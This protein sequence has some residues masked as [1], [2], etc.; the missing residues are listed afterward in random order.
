[1]WSGLSSVATATVTAA[2]SA[3]GGGG[4][5]EHDQQEQRSAATAGA[6]GGKRRT[7]PRLQHVH[8]SNRSSPEPSPERNRLKPFTTAHSNSST[9][10]QRSPIPSSSASK[11]SNTP[12]ALQQ[13]QQ[14][15]YNYETPGT[16]RG[17]YFGSNESERDASNND[18]YGDASSSEDS[19]TELLDAVRGLESSPGQADDSTASALNANGSTGLVGNGGIRRELLVQRRVQEPSQ[20]FGRTAWD[21]WEQALMKPRRS[22]GPR[23]SEGGTTANNSNTSSRRP[24]SLTPNV[25]GTSL[26]SRRRASPSKGSLAQDIAAI[27][28][29]TNRCSSPS[30]PASP[31][32]SAVK[33]SR[34][35]F[36]MDLLLEV[37]I[38]TGAL[39]L[40]AYR[41]ARL[42]TPLNADLEP[43]TPIPLSPFVMLIVAIPC[44][45]LFRRR[46]WQSNYM[47]PFTDER[48]YRT[49]ATVDDGFAAGA[50]VPVL[51]AAGFLWDAVSRGEEGTAYFGSVRPLMDVWTAAGK[52]PPSTASV[53]DFGAVYRTVVVSRISL[54]LSTSINS[55]VLILNIVLSRTFLSVEKVPKDNTKRLLGSLIVSG[56]ISLFLW[57]LLA[58]NDAFA[59]GESDPCDQSVN[60]AD[61]TACTASPY[62]SPAEAAISSFIYQMSLYTISRLVRR[63][64]T[65][66]ELSLATGSGISL[67]LEF[68][69]LTLTRVSLLHAT[70]YGNTL[71]KETTAHIRQT[72]RH[73]TYLPLTDSTRPVSTRYDSRCLHHRFLALTSSCTLSSIRANALTSST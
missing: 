69:R 36:R 66:G 33:Q 16:E 61:D 17:A 68:W 37:I 20:H 47:F 30:A 46:N 6:G 34:V 23:V 62:I 49:P 43:L 67:A 11:S 25:T 9:A 22:P 54:L 57:T 40:T 63:G 51:L 24:R 5:G 29:G 56:T 2:S 13:Q 15:Q 12:P 71:M 26:A 58:L 72:R 27:S 31:A 1:M 10:R 70:A 42:P 19:A 4:G 45:A 28:S 21:Q 50:T 73:P 48:G 39:V 32:G 65:L 3:V 14:Q 38:L 64:F 44:T 59:W 52:L 18:E 41:L 60:L 7:R 53:P 8:S 35:P 55:F